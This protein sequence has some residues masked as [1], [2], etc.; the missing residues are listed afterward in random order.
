MRLSRRRH[1]PRR[2]AGLR[3]EGVLA[4]RAGPLRETSRADAAGA[5]HRRR[6]PRL[7]QPPRLHG[8]VSLDVIVGYSIETPSL[9]RVRRSS[10]APVP[11]WKTWTPPASACPTPPAS[12]LCCSGRR[13]PP[14][15]RRAAWLQTP[16]RRRDQPPH[17]SAP[18]R[19]LRP[20][21]RAKWLIAASARSGARAHPSTAA[22]THGRGC[23]RPECHCWAA[24][25]A[26]AP[27]LRHC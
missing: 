18:A 1:R 2:R 6:R 8:V 25:A 21:R 16:G 13:G 19:G 23:I 10:S 14:P 22:A 17:P 9:H 15:R 20:A 3:D 5:R 24:V 12:P 11:I 26:F 27:R 4:A 7:H